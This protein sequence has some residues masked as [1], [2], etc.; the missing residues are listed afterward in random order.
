MIRTIKFRDHT[1]K[2]EGVSAVRLAALD[3]KE[4]VLLAPC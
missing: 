2:G 3:H 1:A 4:A